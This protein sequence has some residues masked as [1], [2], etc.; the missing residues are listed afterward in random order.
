MSRYGSPGPDAPVPAAN[1]LLSDWPV[2]EIIPWR[3]TRPEAGT[4]LYGRDSYGRGCEL[5]WKRMDGVRERPL[6]PPLSPL[7]K[8]TIYDECKHQAPQSLALAI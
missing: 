6:L 2:Q 5:D 4:Q 7:P 3:H 1:C 8:P